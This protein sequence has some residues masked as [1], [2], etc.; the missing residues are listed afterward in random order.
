MIHCCEFL[1][2]NYTLLPHETRKKVNDLLKSSTDDQ[3]FPISQGVVMKWNLK[4]QK[5]DEIEIELHYLSYLLTLTKELLSFCCNFAKFQAVS[6]VHKI[7]EKG[8]T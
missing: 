1:S 4:K 3:H 7:N 8:S 2:I 6:K 5:D